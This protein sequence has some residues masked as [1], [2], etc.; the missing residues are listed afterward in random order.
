MLKVSIVVLC[1]PHQQWGQQQCGEGDSAG[2]TEAR[3][4]IFAIQR[5]SRYPTAAP[6]TTST[7]IPDFLSTVKSVSICLYQLF[8]GATQRNKLPTN[9]GVSSLVFNVTGTIK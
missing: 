7:Y 1:P 4:V 9:K 3:E 2:G 5:R 6:R 8:Y